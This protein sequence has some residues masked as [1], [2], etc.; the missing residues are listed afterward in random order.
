MPVATTRRRANGNE[1]RCR[2]A[3]RR[4][5]VLAEGEPSLPRV[6]GHEIFEARFVDR[7]LAAPKRPDPRRVLVH[8]GHVMTE[9]GETGSRHQSDIAA[10]DN[11]Q[12][13]EI[14]SAREPADISYP[15]RCEVP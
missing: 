2:P 10:S 1:N 15:P 11:R 3:H 8:A 7:D 4:R 5:D 9:I 13:H 14:P 6:C 12:P